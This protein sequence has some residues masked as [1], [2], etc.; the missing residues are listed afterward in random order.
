MVRCTCPPM[1]PVPKARRVTLMLDLPRVTQSVAV[2]FTA[3]SGSFAVSA[4][5]PAA[6]VVLRN[7]RREW[8]DMRHLVLG[9]HG[10]GSTEARETGT[11]KLRTHGSASITAQKSLGDRL[12][13]L[14]GGLL[15]G[16]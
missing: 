2:C 7:S 6:A 12:G 10:N 3:G 8:R 1:L 13:R 15:E 16:L 4:T 14:V 5:A 11:A 9:G